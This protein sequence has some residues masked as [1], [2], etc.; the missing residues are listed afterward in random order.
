[1]GG[2]ATAPGHHGS[3]SVDI[4]AGLGALWEF[5]WN[6]D[7]IA[8]LPVVLG[9]HHDEHINLHGVLADIDPIH[10]HITANVFGAN[11]ELWND[12]AGQAGRDRWSQLMQSHNVF[13]GHFKDKAKA[14]GDFHGQCNNFNDCLHETFLTIGISIGISVATAW[15]PVTWLASGAAAANA[16]VATDRAWGIVNTVRGVL[17]L[18]K[19]AFAILKGTWAIVTDLGGFVSDAVTFFAELGPNLL[20]LGPRL[21]SLGIDM[22]NAARANPAAVLFN[23]ADTMN[24]QAYINFFLRFGERMWF[25]GD[26]TYAWSPFDANQL[27]LA[28]FQNVLLTSF[29]TGPGVTWKTFTWPWQ[30]DNI[31]GETPMYGPGGLWSRLDGTDAGFLR[32]SLYRTLQAGGTATF[33]N[34]VNHMVF[35]GQGLNFDIPLS[36]ERGTGITLIVNTVVIGGNLLIYLG[37]PPGTGTSGLPQ[38][39]TIPM[40]IGLSGCADLFIPGVREAKGLVFVTSTDNSR[41]GQTGPDI[42]GQKTIDQVKQL[43]QGIQKDT[44]IKPQITTQTVQ[45]GEKIEQIALRQ[46]GQ[47]NP[48]IIADIMQANGIA[49]V[50]DGQVLL[51]PLIPAGDY[52]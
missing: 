13:R 31:L 39:L 44:G 52:Q 23:F 20:K 11:G 28:T 24:S 10:K 3:Q 34:F 1:M 2:A 45:P 46:Y 25:A 15:F 22:F 17:S 8:G 47:V 35:Q 48:K 32:S 6:A 43:L 40:V 36:L 9:N 30:E 12:V 37:Y 51:M 42:V 26:P 19:T 16:A 21:L 38:E 29:L 41:S 14:I 33:Y 49:S 50:Q 7:D 5:V 18:V 27:W 4:A